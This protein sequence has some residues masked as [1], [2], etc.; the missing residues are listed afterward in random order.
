MEQKLE[1]FIFLYKFNGDEYDIGVSYGE[2]LIKRNFNFNSILKINQ[3]QWQ[4]IKKNNN[5]IEFEIIVEKVKKW[6]D[7]IKSEYK[8]FIKIQRGFSDKIGIDIDILLELDILIE[9]SGIFCT[10]YSEENRFYRILDTS[11]E[12]RKCLLETCNEIHILKIND[13][14]VVNHPYYFN[15]HT[16]L[17][18]NFNFFTFGNNLLEKKKYLENEIPFYFKLKKYFINSSCHNDLINFINHDKSIFFDLELII[19]AKENNY[20]IDVMNQQKNKISQIIERSDYSPI[21]INN[22]ENLHNE[23]PDFNRIF[24]LLFQNNKLLI[25]NSLVCNEFIEIPHCFF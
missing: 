3:L 13:Y 4:I 19:N 7:K 11:L 2:F 8:E 15:L 24:V 10:I 1:N 18:K 23:L 22:F 16:V 21:K 14:Y 12:H 20:N 6:I 9:M 5:G 17:F 25:N